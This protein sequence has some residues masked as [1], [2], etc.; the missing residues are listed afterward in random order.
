[1]IKQEINGLKVYLYANNSDFY[2]PLS[3]VMDLAD[4]NYKFKILKNI[5]KNSENILENIIKFLH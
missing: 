2:T 1:M 3:Y 5:I 4:T